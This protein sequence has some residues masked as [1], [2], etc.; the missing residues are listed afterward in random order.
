MWH[1]DLLEISGVA[2]SCKGSREPSPKIEPRLVG[3]PSHLV[4]LCSDEGSA[5]IF[6]K[7][8]SREM[9]IRTP[10]FR[11]D[12]DVVTE[13]WTKISQNRACTGVAL[14]LRQNFLGPG[15]YLSESNVVFHDL[16]DGMI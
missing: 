6:R 5:K 16:Q 15:E 14:S 1:P 8:R 13:E 4:L 7:V 9:D 11:R 3:D 2:R 12:S 10:L